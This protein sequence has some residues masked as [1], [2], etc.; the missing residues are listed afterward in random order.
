MRIAAIAAGLALALAA[1]PGAAAP[2][3]GQ[4]GDDPDRQICKSR[5]VVGSRLKRIRTC[6]TALQWEELKLQERLGMMRRQTNGDAGCNYNPGSTGPCGIH[7]GG[8]DTPW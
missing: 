8:R 3:P 5:P 4:A 6:M 1:S 2:K 7:N